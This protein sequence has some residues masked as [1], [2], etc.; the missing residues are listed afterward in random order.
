VT[1]DDLDRLLSD[2]EQLVPSSGFAAS[3]MAEI[4]GE[5]SVPP[6]LPFP[7]MRAL[8][9]LAALVVALAGTAWNSVGL[10]NDAGSDSFSRELARLFTIAGTPEIGWTA[11]TVVV[12]VLPLFLGLRLTR[13]RV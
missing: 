12:A 13:S 9:G 7:W 3:V 5:A 6:A 1:S 4:G 10:L 2:E 11:L 8:P